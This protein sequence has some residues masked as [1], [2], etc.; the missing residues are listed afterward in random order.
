MLV[1]IS[2]ALLLLTYMHQRTKELRVDIAIPFYKL[3][4]EKA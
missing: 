1:H 4:Y 3:P 2:H